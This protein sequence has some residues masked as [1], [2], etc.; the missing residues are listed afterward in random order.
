MV[1]LTGIPYST[2]H[3]YA[4]R[5][6]KADRYRYIERYSEEVEPIFQVKK[7]FLYRKDRRLYLAAALMGQCGKERT[8]LLSNYPEVVKAIINILGHVAAGD[9][10]MTSSLDITTR[11][12]EPRGCLMHHIAASVYSLRPD[13]LLT[14]KIR[15]RQRITS[16]GEYDY[17]VG[18]VYFPEL[19]YLCGTAPVLIDRYG[20]EIQI[21][22]DDLN[23]AT[24]TDYSPDMMKLLQTYPMHPEARDHREKV[25]VDSTHSYYLYRM[26]WAEYMYAG[27]PLEREK[28]IH[29]MTR[30][31]HEHRGFVIDHLS[32][33]PTDDRIINLMAM[34]NAQNKRKAGIMRRARKIQKPYWFSAT[35]Y[36]NY[37]VWLVTGKYDVEGKR[38]IYD[39]DVLEIDDYLTA[40]EEYVEVTT[41]GRKVYEK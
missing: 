5:K 34:T 19:E 22:R 13:F 32:E 10:L 28:L 27:L 11:D 17:R 24:V 9:Y 39:A 36:D 12:R 7:F 38:R 16:T 25:Y 30:F 40:L 4:S 14:K 33:D 37:H 20:E 31:E 8:Y 2:Y 1:E 41:D 21:W 35:R 15:F 6:L 18:S 3:R 26:R 29:V 23:L